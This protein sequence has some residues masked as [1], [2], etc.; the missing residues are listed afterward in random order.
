LKKPGTIRVVIGPPIETNGVEPR[1]VNERA[2]QWI[3]ATLGRL[4]S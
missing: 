1:V 4:S 2:Q 3:E